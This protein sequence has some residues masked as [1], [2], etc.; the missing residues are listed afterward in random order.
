[1]TEGIDVQ[2]DEIVIHKTAAVGWSE[3]IRDVEQMFYVS[4]RPEV[5]WQLD[6]GG[7]TGRPK[8]NKSK[9]KQQRKSRRRN[10]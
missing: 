8:R 10:R 2:R 6:K 3:G 9:T 7:E 4:A 5:L 1:M